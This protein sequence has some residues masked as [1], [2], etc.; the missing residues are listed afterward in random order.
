MIGIAGKDLRLCAGLG[1][2]Y[3][4]YEQLLLTM[5]A[6]AGTDALVAAV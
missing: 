6:V 4:H 2:L 5:L 1:Q 3:F